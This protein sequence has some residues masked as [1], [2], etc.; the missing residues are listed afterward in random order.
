MWSILIKKI[1]IRKY[2]K[3]NKNINIIS[4]LRKNEF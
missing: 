3:R 1:G 4:E 2:D